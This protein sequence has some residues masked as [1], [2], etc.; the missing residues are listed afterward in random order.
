MLNTTFWSTTKNFDIAKHFMKKN[1]RR[2][3]YII[4]ESSKTN[5]DIDYENLNNFNEE[6]V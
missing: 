4:C 5:I 3:A 6:E 1:S 2:N